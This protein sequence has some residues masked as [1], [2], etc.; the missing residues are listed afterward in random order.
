M[1]GGGESARGHPLSGFE[2]SPTLCGQRSPCET[3]SPPDCRE[4]IT[5]RSDDEIRLVERNVMAAALADD[6]LADA[7]QCDQRRL[8]FVVLLFPLSSGTFSIS[9]RATAV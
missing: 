1:T 5:D 4:Y 6:L 7:R 9:Q 8:I 2:N 3:A